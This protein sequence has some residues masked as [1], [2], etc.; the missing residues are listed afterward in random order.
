MMSATHPSPAVTTDPQRYKTIVIDPPWPGPSEARSLKGGRNVVIPYQ[1]M[2]GIQIAALRIPELAAEGASLWMWVPSR[3]MADAGLLIELWGFRY[4][5]LHIWQKPPGLG[6]WMRHDAEFLLRG[7]LPG[8]AVKLPAPVQTH[9]WKRPRRHSEKPAE[10]YAMI[11]ELC[12]GPRIDIFARQARPGFE[13]WGNEA[14]IASF[15]G[16]PEARPAGNDS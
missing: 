5:G 10:A 15:R 9:H 6:L 3:Q 4:A 7:V 11:A 13:A 12:D 14:P 16:G 1:T 8:A 2:T